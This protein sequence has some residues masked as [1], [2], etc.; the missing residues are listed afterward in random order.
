MLGLLRK[1]VLQL[2][3]LIIRRLTFKNVTHHPAKVSIV[4][5]EAHQHCC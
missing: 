2:S 3:S 4:L 5:A 1:K